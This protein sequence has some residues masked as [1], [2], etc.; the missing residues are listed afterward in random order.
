MQRG[1]VDHRIVAHMDQRPPARAP[2][3]EQPVSVVVHVRVVTAAPRREIE[4][5]LDV[6]RD[7]CGVRVEMQRGVGHGDVRYV[8]RRTPP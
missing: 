8:S 3:V 2:C 4:A 6:D 5:A 7:E 1:T